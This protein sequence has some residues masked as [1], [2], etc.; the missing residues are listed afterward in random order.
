MTPREARLG[1]VALATSL[2]LAASLGVG[3]CSNEEVVLAKVPD[4]PDGGAGNDPKRCAV[5]T[6]CEGA[7]FCA[8]ARCGDVGGTC[9]ARPVLCGDQAAPVCGCDGVTYWNDCLRRAAGVVAGRPGECPFERARL[10]ATT[11]G[12]PK[13]GG[14]EGGESC[15]PGTFC[16]RLLPGLAACS[17]DVPGTC[18][19]LPAVCPIEGGGDRWFRCG[20]PGAR[21]CATTCSAIRTG[22][23]H[24]RA[25]V[26]P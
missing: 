11:K 21:Q 13:P 2:T 24:Q 14:P 12:R 10:C 7:S 17:R 5:D 9:E 16:A 6:E 23:P 22:E 20:G 8:R 3:A 4:E 19:A 18:W 25:T 15:S 26:C 1:V